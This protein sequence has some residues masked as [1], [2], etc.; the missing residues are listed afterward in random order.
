MFIVVM[1]EARGTGGAPCE[2][3]VTLEIEDLRTTMLTYSY[4]LAC[5]CT[6]AHVPLNGSCT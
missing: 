2:E 3:L 4:L 1:C 5:N 6:K